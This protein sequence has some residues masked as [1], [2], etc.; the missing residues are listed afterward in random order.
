[1][2]GL[3]AGDEGAVA[4]TAV[5]V[6]GELTTP[7]LPAGA[8]VASRRCRGRVSAKHMAGTLV[9]GFLVSLTWEWPF[10]LGSASKPLQAGGLPAFA[11]VTHAS[12]GS[13]GGGGSGVRGDG[14]QGSAA[15]A[16][17]TALHARCNDSV[18]AGAP[19]RAVG[20]YLNTA[21]HF[22]TTVALLVYLDAVA[23][24]A[25]AEASAAAA[26]PNNSSTDSAGGHVLADVQGGN[27]QQSAP[28]GA[29]ASAPWAVYLWTQRESPFTAQFGR[30]AFLSGA[31]AQYC[32]WTYLP[33]AG[34]GTGGT[35]RANASLLV[36]GADLPRLDTIFVVT[37]YP[38]ERAETV[39]SSND[40]AYL[41]YLA[42]GTPI[43]GVSHRGDRRATTVGE[44]AGGNGTSPVH[45]VYLAPHVAA[46]G[47]PVFLPARLLPPPV[48]F[49]DAGSTPRWRFLVQGNMQEGR[50]SYSSLLA[51]LLHPAVVAVR[52]RFELLLI[53]DGAVPAELV[54]LPGVTAR[55]HL[56]EAEYH[57]ACR[58]AHFVLP[59]TKPTTHPQYYQDTFSSTI[60]V[61]LAYELGFVVHAAQAQLYALP[62]H[63]VWAYHS[64]RA[65][66]AGELPQ[67]HAKLRESAGGASGAT[68][69][70]RRRLL[71]AVLGPEIGHA[72]VG[73]AAVAASQVAE[74]RRKLEQ[75]PR[76]NDD[77]DGAESR[78]VGIADVLGIWGP[79]P[80][81]PLRYTLHG[82]LLDAFLAAVATTPQQYA[83]TRAAYGP[84]HTAME[85]H[86]VAVLR[87]LVDAGAAGAANTTRALTAAG[88][89][90]QP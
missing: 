33:G 11:P 30:A 53:G 4:T 8:G 47:L 45:I 34:A 60:Q 80:R 23:A 67:V 44:R 14:T 90:R 31:G 41:A 21:F 29:P 49:A 22:E 76:V 83:E 39:S 5:G 26:S 9:C 61:G 75:P 68:R 82:T 69:G 54:K 37:L 52:D 74:A 32:S 20:V 1:M 40:P 57:D 24:S 38:G 50:R 86:N 35:L 71:E 59:L 6:P 7:P 65:V 2:A 28:G 55:I 70:G 36:G 84:Y 18:M 19:R 3:D 10:S 13:G 42:A 17:P 87:G 15:A 89:H 56:N 88:A 72:L 27:L 43:V 78:M 77:D 85:R 81:E 51:V 66:H 12:S 64:M 63:A 79:K 25:A 58:S 62:P 73:D 16:N 46:L 48:P